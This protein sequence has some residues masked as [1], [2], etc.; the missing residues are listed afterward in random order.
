MKA[1]EGDHE[2]ETDE[3]NDPPEE[4]KV[5]RNEQ[6]SEIHE[7]QTLFTSKEEKFSDV[8][9]RKSKNCLVLSKKTKL[10]KKTHKST[11]IRFDDSDKPVKSAIEDIVETHVCETQQKKSKKSK[12]KSVPVKLAKNHTNLQI[13]PELAS[14]PHISK[15]WAQRYR[16]F[17]KYDEGIKLDEESW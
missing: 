12:N 1:V 17:S 9:R 5:V 16:L 10:A 3:D 4:M 14:L 13:P 15:Y 6:T 7:N 11:H 8:R 2:Q